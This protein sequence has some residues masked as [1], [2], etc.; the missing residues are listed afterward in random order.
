MGSWDNGAVIRIARLQNTVSSFRLNQPVQSPNLA[1]NVIPPMR[2]L[3]IYEFQQ[4]PHT[5]PRLYPHTPKLLS[6]WL[7]DRKAKQGN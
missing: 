7:L 3:L 1:T 6:V 4:P 2:H 5:S